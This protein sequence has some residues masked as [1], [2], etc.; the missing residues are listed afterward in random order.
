MNKKQRDTI[1]SICKKLGT[2]KTKFLV[3]NIRNHI[4]D[5]ISVIE[6][7]EW[8]RLSPQYSKEVVD[9]IRSFE[10]HESICIALEMQDEMYSDKLKDSTSTRLVMTSPITGNRIGHTL[11]NFRKIIETANKE[12]ILVG[13]VFNNIEGQMD[14][15][16]ESLMSATSRGINV[17]IFF[18]KGASA[19]TLNN[20][21]KKNKESVPPE[22]FVYKRKDKN[23]VLHA[24]VLIKDDDVIL[25]TS[26]NMTGSAM[27]TNIEFGI[28]HEGKLAMD[29]KKMLYD[30]IEKGY[31]V[32]DN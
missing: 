20:I 15:I 17:K 26:A 2:S 19:K 28:L 22:L 12:I 23:S 5:E 3:D 1:N 16:I 21:W 13:Y 7:Q 10:C 29:A 11:G 30:L 27:E 24:K 18:E 14:P 4:K 8:T 6:I 32:K 31:M 25:V 9:L